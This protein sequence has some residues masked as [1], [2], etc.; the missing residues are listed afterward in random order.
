MSVAP[1]AAG[2]A[3]SGEAVGARAVGSPWE[4]LSMVAGLQRRP[5][6]LERDDLRNPGSS[7][8]KRGTMSFS[9]HTPA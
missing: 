1:A 8:K 4:K 5:A 6:R 7:K 9:P 2:D 3:R